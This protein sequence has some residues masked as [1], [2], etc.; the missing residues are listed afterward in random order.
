MTINFNPIWRT[1][2]NLS[3]QVEGNTIA[4]PLIAISSAQIMVVAGTTQLDLPLAANHISSLKFNGQSSAFTSAGNSLFF[5]ALTHETAID[6]EANTSIVYDLI[7]GSLP[8]GLALGTDGILVG[9]PMGIKDPSG[10]IFE[11]TVRVE[12]GYSVRDRT[13]KML[14]YPVSQTAIWNMAGLPLESFDSS[15]STNSYRLLGDVKRGE[16][17]SFSIDVAHPDGDLVKIGII[18][19]NGILVQ[20]T[21]FNG[22]LPPG[23]ILKGTPLMAWSFRIPHPVDISFHFLF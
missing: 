12:N 5:N 17:F 4:V 20:S 11:F 19:S 7:A 15:L 2:A 9:T 16:A 10:E 22:Q 23:L 1:S 14:I 13:F 6:I 18:S 21:S 8:K 3:D